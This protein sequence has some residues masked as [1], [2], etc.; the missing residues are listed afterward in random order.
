[1]IEE[2]GRELIGCACEAGVQDIYIIPLGEG[3]QIHFRRSECRKLWK[4]VSLEETVT[5]IG[6]FKFLAG[7]NVGER[8]RPQLGSCLYD[9]GKKQ[10]SL[11][12]STVGDYRGLE[13]MV[14]RLL[15]DQEM[16]LHF[17]NQSLSEVAE[18]VRGR[19]LYLFA[20]PVGSG[21]TTLMHAIARIKFSGSQMMSIEDPVEVREDKMLQLQLNEAI[22]MTYD[23]LIKLSLRH[24]PDLL[25]IGEV[26]DCETARAAIRAAL[27]GTTVFTTIHARSVP[28]VYG[29]LLELG[30]TPEE[31]NQ[32][33]RG[34]CYQRLIHGGGVVDAVE[35]D[36]ISHKPDAWNAQIDALLQAGEISDWEAQRE[37]I[38]LG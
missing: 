22:G 11:R 16:D 5:L 10:V 17:W 9:L 14:I 12:L 29:R 37:K 6:H 36:F 18:F 27:T 24:R 38:E 1:M 3:Y 32:A 4:E 26:R 21:K 25:I 28:G 2:F 20:G 30:V 19:G 35:S 7:M 23:S 31:M 33:V 15:Q 34:I 13:S 8:R